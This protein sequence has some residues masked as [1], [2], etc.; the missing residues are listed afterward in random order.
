MQKNKPIRTV[1]A[2]ATSEIHENDDSSYTC[3]WCRAVLRARRDLAQSRHVD[4]YSLNWERDD[5]LTDNLSSHVYSHKTQLIKHNPTNIHKFYSDNQ[6]DSTEYVIHWLHSHLK[7]GH[8]INPLS[9]LEPIESWAKGHASFYAKWLTT[10]GADVF[11][12]PL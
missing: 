7:I 3:N 10:C 1:S 8:W 12:N 9:S 5:W 6:Q 11:E 2:I 4:I